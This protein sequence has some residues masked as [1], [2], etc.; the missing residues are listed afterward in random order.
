MVHNQGWISLKFLPPAMTILVRNGFFFGEWTELFKGIHFRKKVT[1]IV[2]K[3]ENQQSLIILAFLGSWNVHLFLSFD[4]SYI[5]QE[6]TAQ[7]GSLA[8]HTR[9]SATSVSICCHP[10][11]PTQKLP[12]RMHPLKRFSESFNLF[13]SYFFAVTYLM[14]CSKWSTMQVK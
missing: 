12:E 13:N 7:D 10:P 2:V 6:T 9:M 1:I 14:P 8:H 4:V 5:N 11:P 3:Q